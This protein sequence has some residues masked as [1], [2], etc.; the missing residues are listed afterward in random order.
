MRVPH[1]K[2]VLAQAKLESGNYK[3][4]LYKSN[5]NL[6]GMKV[7]T[8]RVSNSSSSNN[9]YQSYCNW[10]ESVMDYVLWQFTNKVDKLTQDEYLD[11]LSQKYAEDPKYVIKLKEIINNLK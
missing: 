5:F 1:Y 9:G 6:F 4:E 8:R 11:Y 3:S 7:V 10:R 2:I